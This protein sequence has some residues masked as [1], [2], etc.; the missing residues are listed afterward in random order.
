VDTASVEVERPSGALGV[1]PAHEPAD[2][3][4]STS[5]VYAVTLD[6]DTGGVLAPR[7]KAERYLSDAK[8]IQGAGR[9][10]RHLD[11]DTTFKEIR[12]VLDGLDEQETKEAPLVMHLMGH[13]FAATVPLSG[14]DSCMGNLLVQCKSCHDQRDAGT[15]DLCEVKPSLSSVAEGAEPGAHWRVLPPYTYRPF[16][17]RSC[18][19][20][21]VASQDIMVTARHLKLLTVRVPLT[22]GN[23]Q[24]LAMLA[25][26]RLGGIIPPLTVTVRDKQLAQDYREGLRQ[27]LGSVLDALGRLVLMVLAAL[28]HL[29][30][31]PSFLLVML[32]VARHYGRRSESDDHMLPAPALQHQHRQGA[33][34]LAV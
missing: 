21:H 34:C 2:Q 23:A 12:A 20:T 1:S 9:A 4:D 18:C 32:A 8:F 17:A 15:P 7:W 33:V 22:E 28:S 5:S 29:A 10:N 13:G 3:A 30:L 16:V 31:V 6:C 14:I 24:M 27:F 11:G 25:F 26:R 19:T